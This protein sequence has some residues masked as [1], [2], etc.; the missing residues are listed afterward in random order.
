MLVCF[1]KYQNICILYIYIY[2]FSYLNFEEL[3]YH[4]PLNFGLVFAG[5][6]LVTYFQEEV[7]GY[8]VGFLVF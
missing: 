6:I 8:G 2:I 7:A 4:V 1:E 5:L 3:Y